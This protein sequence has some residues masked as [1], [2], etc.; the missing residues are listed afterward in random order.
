VAVVVLS[1][2]AQVSGLIG[3][4]SSWLRWGAIAAV[5]YLGVPLLYRYLR[6]NVLWRLRN[7]LALTYILIGLSPVVLFF[8]LVCLSS[9][10]AA[11]QFAIHLAVTRLSSHLEELAMQNGAASHHLGKIIEGGADLS[12]IVMPELETREMDTHDPTSGQLRRQTAA[13]L[14][15]KPLPLAK[16]IG[17]A[18]SPLP[19]PDWFVHGS[20]SAMHAIVIDG[21]SVYLTAINRHDAGNGHTVT[22][23][24]SVLIDRPLMTLVANGLGSAG[25][26]PTLADDERPVSSD[27]KRS[28]AFGERKLSNDEISQ[29]LRGRRDAEHRRVLR[30]ARRLPVST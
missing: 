9:Y 14:D 17:N 18:R 30:L 26:V 15:N 23:I 25:L 4:A 10:V 12:N 8:L 6:S 2:T 13:F 22:L 27:S 19:L 20:S 16:I 5:I 28:Q 11:G 24:S 1:F 21:Q 3:K 7:K 29:V